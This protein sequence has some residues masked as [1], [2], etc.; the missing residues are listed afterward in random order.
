[1]GLR[2]LACVRECSALLGLALAL[3]IDAGDGNLF[4]CA[5]ACDCSLG[6]FLLY[7]HSAASGRPAV[8][9]AISD[10]RPGIGDFRRGRAAA[11]LP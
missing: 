2:S 3:A 7:D 1:M 8:A 4:P 5:C 9:P 10:S 6:R 11:L